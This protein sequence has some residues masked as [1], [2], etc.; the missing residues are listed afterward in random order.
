MK[1]FVGDEKDYEELKKLG[2]AVFIKKGR[3]LVVDSEDLKI[4]GKPELF[5]KLLGCFADLGYDFAVISMA[6]EEIEKIEEKFGFKVPKF[7][8]FNYSQKVPEFE[9]LK[10]ILDKAKNNA[11]DCGA[12]GIFVGFVRRIE[13]DKTVERLEYE[14]FNEILSEKIV[15]LE[16]KVKRFPGIANTKLY[17]RLGKIYPGEDI[18]YIV[19]VGR[20]RKDI[21]EPLIN[22][23]ELMKT[24]L[25]IWK[26][27]VFK[28]GERWV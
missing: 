8:D 23:V 24:E 26:K 16:N 7:E 21:W 11:D 15:E 9:T 6:K 20:H 18:V 14:A 27:E 1:V 28:D 5:E 12:V 10:S 2:K 3:D 17:H 25:P 13:G 4:S 22:S 19:V